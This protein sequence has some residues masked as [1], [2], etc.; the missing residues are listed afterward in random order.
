MVFPTPLLGIFYVISFSIS[1]AL[2][3]NRRRYLQTGVATLATTSSPSQAQAATPKSRTDGYEIQH[4]EREWAYILS[5]PQYNILRQGGTERQKASILN[6]YTAANVGSYTCAGCGTPLF[7]SEEKFS[8]G[9]GWP[10][11]AKP[12]MSTSDLTVSNVEM[13]NVSKIQYQLAGA[14]VRCQTCGGHLGDVFADGYLFP[15]TPAFVTGKRYCIDGAALIFKPEGGGDD[16]YGD[17]PPPN[18]VIRYE[19][20]MY[21]DS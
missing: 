10:S 7:S 3:I 2:S 11:F 15:G 21:R 1:D 5:G 4:T 19:Q 13:E 6:T 14:E 16:V 12:I 20:S 17:E 9:T 8:S 18:K